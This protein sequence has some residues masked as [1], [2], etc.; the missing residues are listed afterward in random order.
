MKSIKHRSLIRLCVMI[1]VGLFFVSG[2]TP[3]VEKM[4][5][6]QDVEGLIK[7]LDNEDE[8]LRH[9]AVDALGNLGDI[10]AVE[11]LIELL[12]DDKSWYLSNVI[13]ALGSLKDPRAVQPLIEIM[14]IEHVRGNA[15]QALGEIGDHQAIVPLISYMGISADEYD[16]ED[17]QEVL[18]K[19]GEAAVLPLI[20]ALKDEDFSLAGRAADLLGEIGDERAIQPLIEALDVYS[21]RNHA[22]F[23]LKKF[24]ETAVEPLI[25]ALMVDHIEYAYY[26]LIQ[27]GSAGTESVL[28]EALDYFS[29]KD[30]AEDYLH[31]GNEQLV[32]A[33]E[34]WASSHGYMIIKRPGWGGPIW[35]HNP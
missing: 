7:V 5:K 1:M 8:E 26:P 32:E 17:I 13:D 18:L 23:S 2:C 12:K 31:S 24:G 11:P 28:I 3:N 4:K 22:A 29:Y 25:H 34:K 14:S 6:N 21:V 16:L 9:E 10:R 20:D 33:A 27:I 19:F 30:M 35:G 15:A